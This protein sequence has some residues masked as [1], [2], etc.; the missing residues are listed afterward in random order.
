MIQ[1]ML[2]LLK[3]NQMKRIKKVS[4]QTKKLDIWKD[5]WKLV[6]I[7][8]WATDTMP[9]GNVDGNSPP[10]A[11][12]WLCSRSCNCPESEAELYFTKSDVDALSLY[13]CWYW[14]ICDAGFCRK[15]RQCAK[16]K[17]RC[18]T[19]ILILIHLMRRCKKCRPIWP[20]KEKLT[21]GGPII[22]ESLNR[23]RGCIRKLC[24]GL[25]GC[26]DVKGNYHKL[27]DSYIGESNTIRKIFDETIFDKYIQISN[28]SNFFFR[29]GR[30]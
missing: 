16:K 15:C 11:S 18:K 21:H 9:A 8:V 23:F 1:C 22:A 25:K 19:C 3:Q 12:G 30:L 4:A 14:H 2:W 7:T 26:K 28:A 27:G 13:S 24:P 10:I 20:C 29:S 5:G 6:R 17:G